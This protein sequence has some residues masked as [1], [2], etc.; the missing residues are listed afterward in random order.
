[1]PASF[2]GALLLGA[3]AAA[4]LLPSAAAARSIVLEHFDAEITVEPGGD[5][6]VVE[7]LDLRFE[8]RWNGIVRSIP[9]EYRGAGGLNYTL[10][11]DVVAVTDP[12]G[13]RLKR[14]LS[15]R[16]HY[17]EIKI[18]IPGAVD[19]ERTVVLHY[20]VRNALRFFDTHD[21]L[22]WNVTG[23]EWEFPIV[24]A[25]ATV[26]LPEEATGIRASAF[27]GVYGSR[28]QDASVRV[29]GS[30]VRITTD[31]NLGFRQ[32]LSVVVGWDKGVVEEP[33]FFRRAGLFLRSNWPFG[34]PVAVLAV[35]GGLW[36]RRGRD[37][38][39]RP[40][41]VRYEPPGSL[42]PAEAGTLV[43]HSPDMQDLTATIID[44]AVRGYLDIE[45][46]PGPEGVFGYFAKPDYTFRRRAPDGEDLRPH[47][48]AIL[49]GLFRD[50]TT[51]RLSDL[52]HVFYKDLPGIRDRIYE[53]LLGQRCYDH[54]PDRTKRGAF[55]AGA[56]LAGGGF[57]LSG[58]LSGWSGIAPLTFQLAT[59]AS[60][61]VV[62]AFGWLLPARTVRGTRVL[63]EV[64]GFQQ[65]LDRV[66]G[67]RLE[68]VPPTPETFER[69]LPWA[70][71]LGVEQNWAKAFEGIVKEPPKWYRGRGGG[72]F[73]A[74]GFADDLGSLSARAGTVLASAPRRSGGSGFGGGGFS[75]GGFGGGGGR[76]F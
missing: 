40:V 1:M 55:I 10:L 67:D 34:L 76:G 45:E 46:E 64:L 6:R 36:F 50:G 41:A 33:G 24:S 17:R 7:T 27:T 12:A 32:G 38:A 62:A 71:A 29:A 31:R 18:W 56:V 52:E 72:P 59:G 74:R 20:R 73:R 14:E 37:P 48:R 8:G 9:V 54:R 21:E 58:A 5:V 28:Q 16:R 23:D 49:A 47:D 39:R 26:L 3:V 13:R 2:A 75:G 60:G 57:A 66:E 22:Y 53:A 25:S 43:D 44:L 11:L 42:S 51:V 70:M 65:F 68:R 30:A 61:A 4:L 19:A 63:E 35:M 15:R 69:Y